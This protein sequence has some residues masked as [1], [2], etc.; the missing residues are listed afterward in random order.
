MGYTWFLIFIISL[1]LA[2]GVLIMI[3]VKDKL[4][5]ESKGDIYKM[6]KQLKSAFKR[7]P[8]IVII[9]FM[10][11]ASCSVTVISLG[12]CIIYLKFEVM[13]ITIWSCFFLGPWYPH[14]YTIPYNVQWK[15]LVLNEVT[16]KCFLLYKFNIKYIVSLFF[17]KLKNK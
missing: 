11:F 13:F 9:W 5:N 10:I 2:T 16:I 17:E 1:Q 8:N 3:F 14:N 6:L 7:K 12:N 4:N 15:D